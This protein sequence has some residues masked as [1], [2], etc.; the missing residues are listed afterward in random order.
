MAAQAQK[1]AEQEQLAVVRAQQQTARQI[2]HG[3]RTIQKTTEPATTW[4]TNLP[5]PGGIATLLI[6]IL[7]FLM[8]IVPSQEVADPNNPGK[9][10]YYTRL[11]LLWLT[12]LGRTSLKPHNSSGSS[13]GSSNTNNAMNTS[14]IPV[15]WGAS[16]SPTTINPLDI[17]PSGFDILGGLG[18][19]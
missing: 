3:I 2:Q 15:N 10:I 18:L 4:M 13:G 1:D 17:A 9:Y 6:I 5:T 7:V 14:T 8:A 12:I 19:Q 11:N 16:T